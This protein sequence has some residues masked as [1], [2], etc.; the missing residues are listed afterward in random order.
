VAFLGLGLPLLFALSVPL[1]SQRE[2]VTIRQVEYNGDQPQ[3]V[4][5]Q[6]TINNFHSERTWW[7]L[8][9]S[10][11]VVLADAAPT[12]SGLRDYDFDPLTAIRT[13]VRDARLGSDREIDHCA[14]DLNDQQAFFDAQQRQR[15]ADRERLGVTWPF[16][17]AAD[18]AL[19]GLFSVIAVRRL[20]TPTRTLPRGTRVA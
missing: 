20:R 6:E 11:Y 7:L 15:A 10:P 14:T 3:C 8:A 2:V 13:G 17:L 16:G 4:T 1:A 9:A 12:P 5:R 19:G 18:L